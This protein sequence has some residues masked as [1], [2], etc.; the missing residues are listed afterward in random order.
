MSKRQLFVVMVATLLF[1]GSQS[2]GAQSDKPSGGSSAHSHLPKFE[3]GA[4][5]TTVGIGRTY[6]GGTRRQEL[7]ECRTF[8]P[9]VYLALGD[10][11]G[12]G[13]GSNNA[14]GYARRLF[15]RIQHSR[16]EVL[17]VNRCH[18]GATT[19]DLLQLQM[20]DL[21]EIHPTFI[22]VGVGA[23]DLIRGVTPEDFGRNYESI[24]L[25]LKGQ[26]KAEI[27]LMNIPDLS[28]APA[29]PGYMRET[30][31]R[32]IISFNKQIKVIAERHKVVVVDLY[33]MT[34]E[35]C[36]HPTFFSE[37]GIHPSDTGYE[38]WAEAIWPTVQVAL[39]KQGCR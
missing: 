16:P 26:T 24:L 31:R 33:A 10:S 34:P 38:F 15:M 28:L 25:R 3:S 18:Y 20:K 6:T 36:K 1:L 9:Y 4:H 14:S 27:I 7:P 2:P 5:F 19:L 21:S 29:V 35:F 37:D 13:A 32:H 30:A 17:F 39:N 12:A 11:T 23:N 22:T 8:L